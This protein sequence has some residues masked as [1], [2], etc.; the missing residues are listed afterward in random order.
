MA[1]R[2][3]TPR[4]PPYPV[5][6]P[7][8]ALRAPQAAPQTAPASDRCPEV[9]K[10]PQ[11]QNSP[12]SWPVWKS[13]RPL[14]DRLRIRPGGI[15]RNR[16]GLP[17]VER[18]MLGPG[19]TRTEAGSD[20]MPTIHRALRNLALGL[21]AAWLWC[22]QAC[23]KTSEAVRPNDAH[24]AAGSRSSQHPGADASSTDGRMILVGAVQTP[25]DDDGGALTSR[26]I[27]DC[28]S[29]PDPRDE[30]IELK[31]HIVVRPE[32]TTAVLTI[33]D[34]CVTGYRRDESTLLADTEQCRVVWTT[35]DDRD[36]RIDIVGAMSDSG[37]LYCAIS[38]NLVS[39]CSK[40]GPFLCRE[41]GEHCLQDAVC[42]SARCVQSAC[43]EPPPASHPA[44]PPPGLPGAR[45]C[46]GPGQICQDDEACCNQMCIL[47][48][49]PCGDSAQ[50]RS[51]SPPQQPSA[52]KTCGHCYQMKAPMPPKPDV[53]DYTCTGQTAQ[54]R[55]DCQ[56]A[57]GTDNH[58]ER[59]SNIITC[60]VDDVG[61]A[62]SCDLGPCDRHQ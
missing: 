59:L 35:S 55:L 41:R 33:G 49:T 9:P 32:Q 13:L 47:D 2:L 7:S 1:R 23:T 34:R 4:P 37:P 14:L 36:C 3:E 61:C 50:A 24:A 6:S 60:P 58:C 53:G 5:G 57:L 21:C 43:Q 39:V 26:P 31:E 56:I 51:G 11:V 28:A 25:A 54:G 18:D 40:K 15:A 10:L 46:Q 52:P 19:S 12:E 17:R 22:Q 42:C 38:Y 62:C 45:G 20:G 27:V 44:V 48:S 29:A 30:F 8:H 16:S